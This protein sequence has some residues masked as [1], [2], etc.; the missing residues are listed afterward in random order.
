LDDHLLNAWTRDAPLSKRRGGEEIVMKTGNLARYG[1]AFVASL[2]GCASSG[3]PTA[4]NAPPKIGSEHRTVADVDVIEDKPAKPTP[5]SLVELGRL[6]AAAKKVDLAE[7]MFNDAL[8]LDKKYIPAYVS[9]AQLY[10]ALNDEAKGTAALKKALSIDPNAPL[11]WNEIA[12]YRAK[13]QDFKGAI[14]AAERG[15][16][17]APDSPL[18][19]ENLGGLYAVTGEFAQ[20]YQVFCKAFSPAEAHYRIAGVMFKQGQRGESAEQLQLAVQQ[21]P[22]HQPSIRMLKHLQDSGAA[23]VALSNPAYRAPQND[24]MVQATAASSQGAPAEQQ[25][26]RRA[27]VVDGD[28]AEP[29]NQ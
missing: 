7:R 22:S 1:L 2:A 19:L 6:N 25:S 5:K 27:V 21:D 29:A 17:T 8:K 10:F 26:V 23:A 12:I 9:K 3:K 13:K 24:G 28:P 16:R 15:L 18:L 4:L 14:E 20:A 11:V